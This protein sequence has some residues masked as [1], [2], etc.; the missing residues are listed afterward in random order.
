MS[1]WNLPQW[2]SPIRHRAAKEAADSQGSRDSRLLEEGLQNA[3]RAGKITQCKLSR[4]NN[5]TSID[6]YY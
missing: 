4:Y 1:S 3:I 2:L 5:E 6:N